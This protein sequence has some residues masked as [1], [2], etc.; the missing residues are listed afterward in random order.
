MH[1]IDLAQFTR[2]C[3][4]LAYT[5][6]ILGV[7]ADNGGTSRINKLFGAVYAS[8]AAPQVLGRRGT[9]LDP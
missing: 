8:W 1:C 2:H 4:K 7:A 9:M 6:K 3:T 5:L